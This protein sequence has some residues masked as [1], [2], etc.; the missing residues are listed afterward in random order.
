MTKTT[1]GIKTGISVLGALKNKR[2]HNRLE[3]AIVYTQKMATFSNSF[4][5]SANMKVNKLWAILKQTS[6]KIKN[7]QYHIKKI[8]LAHNKLVKSHK[9][10]Y[11]KIKEQ[12]TQIDKLKHQL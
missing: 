2:D 1:E 11:K 8:F 4:A 7:N 12:Q 10:L 6:N 9:D 5:T 3:D